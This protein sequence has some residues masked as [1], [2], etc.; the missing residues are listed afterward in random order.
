MCTRAYPGLSATSFRKCSMQS[1]VR[2]GVVVMRKRKAT[3]QKCIK[4]KESLFRDSK[5]VL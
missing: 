2:D 5:C 3:H 1:M 4:K